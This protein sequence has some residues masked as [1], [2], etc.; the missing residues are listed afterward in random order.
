MNLES[1]MTMY[2]SDEEEQERQ[3]MLAGEMIP[4]SDPR[5]QAGLARVRAFYD[6]CAAA[7]WDYEYSESFSAWKSG[8][9]KIAEL[10]GKA[11]PFADQRAIFEAF[12]AHASWHGNPKPERP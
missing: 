5:I 3:E 4:E 9:D 7:D 2:L 1:M 8:R 12:N 6:E 11:E 10:R